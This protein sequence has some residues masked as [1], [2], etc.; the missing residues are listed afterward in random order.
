MQEELERFKQS[1]QTQS[2]GN[3]GTVGAKP[4]LTA[5]FKPQPKSTTSNPKGCIGFNCSKTSSV[6]PTNTT[7]GAPEGMRRQIGFGK[8]DT[9]IPD[10]A[11][12]AVNGKGGVQDFTAKGTTGPQGR[13]P[14]GPEGLRQPE[15]PGTSSR[16][17]YEIQD[18]VGGTNSPT[19]NSSERVTPIKQRNDWTPP[20]TTV[21]QTLDVFDDEISKLEAERKKMGLFSSREKKAELDRQIKALKEQ[22][23]KLFNSIDGKPLT[24]NSPIYDNVVTTKKTEV[25]QYLNSVPAKDPATARAKN[26]YVDL[27]NRY[28]SVNVDALPPSQ[29]ASFLKSFDELSN[30]RFT[31][32]LATG[33]E[34]IAYRQKLLNLRSSLDGINTNVYHIRFG[35]AGLG[36]REWFARTKSGLKQQHFGAI[37]ETDPS[38]SLQHFKKEIDKLSGPKGFK[39]TPLVDFTAHGY[40]YGTPQKGGASWHGTFGNGADNTISEIVDIFDDGQQYNLYFRNCHGGAAMDDFLAMPKNKTKKLNMFTEAGRNQKNAIEVPNLNSSNSLGA[41]IDNISYSIGR[42]NIGSRAVV[43]GQHYY[44]L[45]TAITQARSN[46]NTVLAK[47]LDIYKTLMETSDPSEFA[48]AS[49]QYTQLFPGSPAPTSPGFT[50]TTRQADVVPGK[51]L[52]VDKDIAQYVKQVGDNMLGKLKGLGKAKTVVPQKVNPNIITLPEPTKQVVKGGTSRLSI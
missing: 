32:A 23:A 3:E 6:A 10:D 7:S 25:E 34:G 20:E 36:E 21:Q 27:Y 19:T 5:G 1:L 18:S 52:F 33:P 28:L 43:D 22:R 29:R 39:E 4:E 16:N 24:T 12:K 37:R 42:G 49:R 2:K 50:I 8:S 47:K 17:P 9:Y 38:I 35:G 40:L 31:D 26:E 44:P 51:V 48:R 15:K 13:G 45:E 41:A 46:G 11:G 30:L 14:Q